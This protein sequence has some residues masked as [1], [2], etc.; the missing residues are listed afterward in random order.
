MT[1]G[2]DWT[3]Q[4]ATT[5]INPRTEDD[6]TATDDTAAATYHL[7][8]WIKC[9]SNSEVL[10]VDRLKCIADDVAKV[11]VENAELRKLAHASPAVGMAGNAF[12]N[13]WYA[14]FEA[15]GALG[16]VE[17]EKAWREYRT[18]MA[19][20]LADADT[21]PLATMRM[22]ARVKYR[23]TPAGLAVL[24]EEASADV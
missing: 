6:V 3:C 1:I 9:R 24:A 21:D 17:R 18:Q 22:P 11:L 13:G 14:A 19:E 23:A 7:S 5:D 12:V 15:I 8:E 16:W 10:S 20:L 4:P 2:D